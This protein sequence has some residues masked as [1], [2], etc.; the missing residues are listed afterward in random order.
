MR[1]L[2]TAEIWALRRGAGCKQELRKREYSA[3]IE[4]HLSSSWIDACDL[5]PQHQSNAI[6]RKEIAIAQWQ[7][8]IAESAVEVILGKQ[9]AVVRRPR[10]IG[11]HRDLAGKTATQQ[12]VD[13]GETRRAAADHDEA[14]V[15][16]CVMPKAY[17]RRRGSL[18]P[19]PNAIVLERNLPT[20]HRVEC[21]SCQRLART[22][23]E[24]GVMPR[25]A[26]GVINDQSLVERSAQMAAGGADREDFVPQAGEQRLGATDMAFLDTAIGEVG[27]SNASGKIGS[28]VGRVAQGFLWM[29]PTCKPQMSAGQDEGRDG[30][31][32][33]PKLG[34][35]DFTPCR[36]RRAMV[37]FAGSQLGGPPAWHNIGA[38]L[39]A[40]RIRALAKPP[41]ACYRQCIRLQG[42]RR[43]RWHGG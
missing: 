23:A 6:L 38:A 21:R 16:S 3:V 10:V 22:Q 40:E 36:T 28:E 27:N 26:H 13:C 18:I 20:G 39:H 14:V 8:I 41:L 25:A 4:Y 24:A 19:H 2:R 12:H 30:T 31:L 33:A 42:P 5:R 43:S 34:G 37:P 35:N 32:V 1:Q 11:D 9:G 17:G 29:L 7:M 15:R